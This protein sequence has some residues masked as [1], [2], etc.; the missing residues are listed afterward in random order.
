MNPEEFCIVRVFVFQICMKEYH[1]SCE[2]LSLK[3]AE[4]MA[5]SEF[6]LGE[7]VVEHPGE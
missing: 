4:A 5:A 6:V 3:L 7:V 2:D 1:A